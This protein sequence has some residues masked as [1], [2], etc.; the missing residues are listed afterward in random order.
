MK[1]TLISEFGIILFVFAIVA[2][3][4]QTLDFSTT[5]LGKLASICI[6]AYYTMLDK[7][8]GFLAAAIVIL[9]HHHAHLKNAFLTE[10]FGKDDF[11]KAHC[12]D[13]KLK[14]KTSTVNPEMAV[15]VFPEIKYNQPEN[16]CHPCDAACN[17]TILE[18]RLAKENELMMPKKDEGASQLVESILDY[19]RVPKATNGV[20][21]EPFS[22][23]V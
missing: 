14:Y 17:Y 6:I 3:T 7:L 10:G 21:T 11:M 15:H 23:F 2:Y 13:G 4:K 8:Y 9:V 22:N 5:I 19:W 1:N 18:D 20:A 12:Q 16:R